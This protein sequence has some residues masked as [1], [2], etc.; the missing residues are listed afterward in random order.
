MIIGCLSLWSISCTAG[1]CETPTSVVCARKISNGIRLR[2][3]QARISPSYGFHAG[4]VRFGCIWEKYT[5]LSLKNQSH[6]VLV[7]FVLLMLVLDGPHITGL[8]FIKVT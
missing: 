6:L 7:L 1:E 3:E 2:R 4:P 8:E 5:V